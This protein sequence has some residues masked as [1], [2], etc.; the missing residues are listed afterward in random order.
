MKKTQDFLKY[1]NELW[2]SNINEIVE[3]CENDEI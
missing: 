3:Y 1:R 2:K